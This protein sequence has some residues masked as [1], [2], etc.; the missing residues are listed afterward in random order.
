MNPIRTF[1]SR[2][3][4]TGMLTL[5]V[6]VFGLV[7]YPRIG[8]D[9][10]PDV[11]FP[12]V[13][14]TTILPG[15]DPEAI[16][17][18]V[19]DP[20]EE[21]LN[22]LPGLDTLRSV[23]VDNVSQ[24]IVRFDLERN[25]DVAAQDV[26]DKVQ[27]TLSKLPEEIEAPVVQKFDI[28]AIPVATLAFSAPVPIDRLTK[29]A[30]DVVKPSL[31]QIAGVGSVN[32]VG[33]RRREITVVIDPSLAKG[34]GL[35]PADVVA[36]I[37]G[38]SIDVPGGRTLEP[39][40]E[41]SVK[42]AG[43]ARSVEALRALP[44]ASPGGVPVRLGQ[45]ADV[46]DGPAEARGSAALSGKGALGL[47][48]QKQSGSNTVKVAEA[49]K[50]ALG[51]VEQQLPPGSRM[52][53]VVDGSKFIRSSIDAVKEDMLLGGILAV[54][55]VLIFLRN[56]RSTLVS[57]VALPTAII[58]T[59]A[60]M[61]ALGF[62]FNVITMLALTLSIGLLIDDAIVVIENIV[63]HVEE[64]ETPWEA[65]RKGTSEIALAVLAVTLAVVAVF[66]PVAFMEGI[67]G[68]FFYQFGVTVA[69]AVVISYLV[70]MTLTPMLSARV[71]KEHAAHGR[72]F[73]AIERALSRVEAFYRRA[74]AWVLSRRALTMAAASLVLLMTC[75]LGTRLKGTFMPQQ[76]MSMVKVAL[77]LP[78]GTALGETRGQLD[79]LARQIRVVPGVK[80][81]FVTAGGGQLEEVNKGE[82][83]V[84]VVP[85]AQRAYG[86]ADLK[87]YLRRTLRV[88]P[89]AVLSVQDYNPM[90][91]GGNRAQVIQFNLRS[92]SFEELLAAV[93][94]TKAKLRTNPGFV[95]VDTTWRTGKPQLDVVVDRERAAAMGIPAA[96]LG[97]NVR[98]LMGGDK[99]ADFHEGGDTWDIKVRLPPAVLA[100]PGAIGAIPVRAS[101]GQ[102][103]ELRAVADVRPAQ[104]PSQID[105]QA[106]M[107]QVTILADLRPA[108]SL[109]EAMKYLDDFAKAEL[110]RTVITDWEGQARE[111][112][113][114]LT[115]FGLALGLGVVLVYIILAAQFES[116]VHP[117]TIMMALPFALIGGIAGIIL[118][119][120]QV[121][122]MVMIGFIMLMGL[123]TKNGILLV[124]FTNQLRERG[125][126]VKEALLE[127]GPVRLRPILM[128][129]VAMIAGMIPV[130][131][132]RGDGAETRV[133]MAVTIIGGL[134]TSTVLT[135]G[136]VPVVY[137]LVDQ[138]RNWAWRKVTK[139]EP[140]Q[141]ANRA[142]AE[143]EVAP[144]VQPAA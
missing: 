64:G 67:M 126:S 106:Q 69:V 74:L 78:S 18:T 28:G 133:P 87:D 56:F 140:P 34:Y 7:A 72:V 95:D 144:P 30:E 33:G 73:L 93:E 21:A 100:D 45:V 31:Q 118:A 103:V 101:T 81:T 130:A 115:S 22:T 96:A 17:K 102:L 47:V 46:Q 122:M 53:V 48:V 109:G 117:F 54:L 98:A 5:A 125:K 11:D 71:I 114:M 8:V 51:R 92:A 141:P 35:S 104:G 12:I 16:E 10:F 6:L 83:V 32:I 84:D 137:S 138:L 62:T 44:I 38:Q 42:L 4:F 3:V 58:G 132:A 60:V 90:A 85:L 25:V 1:I 136:I 77:E 61:R 37:R 23:N 57:A 65:A 68:R 91:G 110:P 40:V 99:V 26:R 75:G 111:F 20:L 79:D 121:S 70:S 13:T 113:K 36:A 49:V 116:L 107:R 19:T 15:A 88:S 123:V 112:G 29:L 124:E 89:A 59:F 135:L 108:Y 128:T 134:V 80:D 127:A 105:R 119:R 97:Q 41:R 39:G 24:I 86:Q 50:E 76:D 129:S 55:V 66:V 63:R 131:L 94:K 142:P 2:P 82:I 52:T 143:V 14:V 9:Q 120:Q 139:R 27:A 43:E